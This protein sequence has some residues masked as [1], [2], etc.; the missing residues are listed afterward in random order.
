M[1]K[2]EELEQLKERI[3]ELKSKSAVIEQGL[4]QKR[5]EREQ[6]AA[7]LRE[8][9]VDI[10]ADLNKTQEELDDRIQEISAKTISQIEFWEK[11]MAELKEKLF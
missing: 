2:K 8:M 9:G 11:R 7:E 5:K 3:N 1:L 10:D 4:A 6:K